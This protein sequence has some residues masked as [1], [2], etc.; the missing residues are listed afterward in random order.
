M[1]MEYTDQIFGKDCCPN[2]IY[3]FE[4]NPLTNNFDSIYYY[5]PSQYD[6][7]FSGFAIGDIN[8]NGK[9]EFFAGSVNGKIVA[10]ENCGDNCYQKIWNT[11]LPT[12]NA[13]LYAVTNDMD[14]NGKPEVWLGGYHFE[15]GTSKI[16]LLIFEA[17][18]NNDYVAVGKIDLLGPFNWYC[19]NTQV[20]DVDKDGKDEIMLAVEQNVVILKFNGSINHQSFEVFYAKGNDL[21]KDGRYSV[22]YGATMYGVTNDGKEDII[23]HMDEII[24]NVGIRFFTFIYKSDIVLDVNEPELI[25]TKFQVYQNHPN[26]FNPSTFIRF[27]LVHNSDVTLK[28]YN[29]LGKEI[30]TLTQ[31]GLS[32][33]THTINWEA[34]DNNGQLLP[35][36][37]YL[38][39]INAVSEYNS[40]TKTIKSVLLK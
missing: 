22:F 6:F 10:F 20:L 7:Y 26:P 11:T 5:D 23:I 33:G 2:T 18:I 37:I 12:Y 38:L 4:Y 27:D 9:A 34:K 15:D 19:N 35:S 40:D 28:V 21:V 29:I 24:P 3:I 39:K 31:E 14:N 25:P 32:P 16:R 17:G 36:G 30:V 13:Y 8:Q 1:V